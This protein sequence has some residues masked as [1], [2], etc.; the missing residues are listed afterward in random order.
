MV[1]A[2]R[3][4]SLVHTV[5]GISGAVCTRLSFLFESLHGYKVFAHLLPIA[6][7]VKC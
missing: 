5:C 6:L 4:S 2:E 3:S 7:A 1:G